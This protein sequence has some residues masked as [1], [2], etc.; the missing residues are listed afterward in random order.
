MENVYTLSGELLVD[1][2]AFQRSL[3][4]ADSR[5]KGT[6]TEI[7]KTE[8][9]A[10]SM[11]STSAVVSRGFEKMNQAVDVQRAKL[12]NA[13]QAY[14]SGAI[15]GKQYAAVVG[16][17]ERATQQLNG[18]IGD[19]K[20]KLD[21]SKGSLTQLIGP[22]LLL[23]TASAAGGKSVLDYSS[24]L[25]QAKIGFETMTGSVAVATQHLKELQVFAAKTPFRFEQIVDASRKLQGV[26]IEA[27][28]VIPILNDVGNSLAAA[29]RLDELPLAIKAL[30]DI[31]AKGKLAGQE[32]IQ[33]AN[34]GIPIRD[35]LAKSLGVSTA[36]VIKLGEDGQISADQVFQAIHKLSEEKFGD[37]MAK[38]SKTFGGAMSNVLDI[39][40][41]S[42]AKAFEPLYKEVS[43]LANKTADKVAT[44]QND[45]VGVGL[46]IGDAIGAGILLGVEKAVVSLPEV[47]AREVSTGTII[48]RAAKQYG[49][50]AGQRILDLAGYSTPKPQQFGPFNSDITGQGGVADTGPATGSVTDSISERFKEETK[51][52]GAINKLNQQKAAKQLQLLL[53]DNNAT[54]KQL[55][56]GLASIGKFGFD[57]D[58]QD[59]FVQRFGEKIQG[60]AEKA[61][62]AADDLRE[63]VKKF[64][65]DVR[66]ILVTGSDNPIVKVF[67]E[68]EAAI[69]RIN[70]ATKYA[71]GNIRKML[72]D[73]AK[74]K[75]A[76]DTATARINNRLESAGLRDTASRFRS[77][78]NPDGF[79]SSGQQSLFDFY[80][81]RDAA[82][83]FE[84][85]NR[86]SQF[87]SPEEREA[88]KS[89]YIQDYTDQR[90]NRRLQGDLQRRLDAIN[91]GSIGKL[92]P[93]S[94]DYQRQK[95]IN[96]VR[97]MHTPEKDRAILDATKGLDPSKLTGNQNATI[98][99]AAENEAKRIA[100]QEKQAEEFYKKMTAI[101]GENGLKVTVAE[102][103]NFVKFV[104]TPS[105]VRVSGPAA[106]NARY[107]N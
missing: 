20:A 68:G 80:N 57:E 70:E 71:G 95:F 85:R 32:I 29:G 102:G 66:D 76:S 64:K 16:Q 72:T 107:P 105:D 25:E 97:E 6:R 53:S 44:Q 92:D 94:S 33:L 103:Q 30:G 75:T 35:T 67:G 4:G 22:L 43:Q 100:E 42:S 84:N 93:N 98:A 1:T 99:R 65:D 5:L 78:L 91:G 77:G 88:A 19:M 55:K 89:S 27:N 14:S 51:N 82:N 90:G 60:L 10:K 59:G 86:Y 52:F 23:A 3:L 63:K 45:F 106:T 47:I 13:A 28:K 37:A 8:A 24:N 48:T 17:V 26:G 41:Q 40:Q 31:Q 101:I 50:R 15:T 73:L 87:N 39:V 2:N 11:G 96:A 56:N 81:H 18:K 54:S 79:A 74:A 38:Q 12:S 58:T 62:K 34:A 7:E 69:E 36:E 9:A 21:D 46:T 49:D 104:N 83:D 61:K